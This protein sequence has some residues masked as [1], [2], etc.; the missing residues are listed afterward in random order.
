MQ[1]GAADAGGERLRG[2]VVH[3]QLAEAAAVVGAGIA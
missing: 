2:R 3:G 1:V